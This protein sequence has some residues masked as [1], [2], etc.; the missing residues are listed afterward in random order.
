MIMIS[1]DYI[2][3]F[4]LEEYVM[5]IVKLAHTTHQLKQFPEFIDNSLRALEYLFVV[6]CV[7]LRL[8]ISFL[9]Q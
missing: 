3:A 6:V 4:N 8:E 5:T 7:L 9:K 1:E 2:F